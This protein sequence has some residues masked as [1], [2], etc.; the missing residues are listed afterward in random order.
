M[1]ENREKEWIIIYCHDN[2]DDKSNLYVGELISAFKILGFSVY[3]IN[4]KEDIRKE[5]TVISNKKIKLSLGI[6]GAGADIKCDDGSLL[7][8]KLAS[9]YYCI[10]SRHPAYYDN[11]LSRKINDYYVLC[12]DS[13]HID[14]IKRIYTHIKNAAIAQFI[15]YKE[16]GQ[17]HYHE[18]KYD[19]VYLDDNLNPDSILD[20]IDRIGNQDIINSVY[21]VIKKMFGN[22]HLSV[23]EAFDEVI[24][25]NYLSLNKE[26]Y[27]D[28]MC[29]MVL[30]EKYVYNYVKGIVIKKLI[31]NGISI[32]VFGKGWEQFDS[33]QKSNLKIHDSISY[34]EIEDVMKQSGI[35]LNILCNLKF[36][37]YD[38]VYM[39]AIAGAACVTDERKC[40]ND[41]FSH[42]EIGI[43]SL[44]RIQELSDLLIQLRNDDNRVKRLFENANSVMLKNY[45]WN[46]IADSVFGL[47]REDSIKSYIGEKGREYIADRYEDTQ[48]KL[49]YDLIQYG[50]KLLLSHNNHVYYNEFQ[51][52]SQRLIKLYQKEDRK[53][54]QDWIETLGDNK[55]LMMSVYSIMIRLTEDNVYMNKMLDIV[56]NSAF[57]YSIKLTVYWYISNYFFMR[58]NNATQ[59]TV[60]KLYQLYFEVVN[61]IGQ[62]C[63]LSYQYRL[64]ADR[65][66]DRVIVITSQFLDLRHGPTKTALD[67]CECLIKDFGMQVFLI[68]TGDLMYADPVICFYDMKEGSYVDDYVNRSSVVYNDCTI[69]FYQC[70][71]GMPDKKEIVEIARFIWEIN[72]YFILSIGGGN[73]TADICSEFCP[74]LS[75]ATVPSALTVTKGQFQVLGR[76]LN[77]YDKGI[78]RGLNIS[79]NHVIE[80]LFTSSLKQQMNHYSRKILGI[81]EEYFACILVGG[82]LDDELDNELVEKLLHDTEKNV[83]IV[84]AGKYE[85]YGSKSGSL[86]KFAE[87]FIYLGFQD[88]MLAV[89]E[90]CD[91]Y[92]NPL[93]TGG[94]TSAAEAMYKG[95]PVVTLPVGDVALGAG[96]YFHV[97]DYNEMIVKINRYSKDKRFYEEDSRRAK[98]RAQILFDTSKEFGS[99][100][101][102]MIQRM[103]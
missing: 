60:V 90:C 54:L 49:I 81:P 25:N 95:L 78:L 63:H 85:L 3:T 45:T 62:E 71:K 67:R 47:M 96:E 36:G 16:D 80:G 7:Q 97:K 20:E 24:E 76:Q 12:S 72:P 53:K 28:Y 43:F 70:K 2:V 39:S 40:I 56:L 46:K 10:I 88:D 48:E 34:S 86:E 69:P 98:K 38:E 89:L 33:S 8:N 9:P 21:N 4:V 37:G 5:I 18:K 35:V 66:I 11:I 26:E 65:N 29:Y 17:L 99:I 75:L 102:K 73:V 6:E 27:T 92:I 19:I 51:I 84:I 13:K 41:V 94:G 31:E 15:G 55:L 79:E 42:N 91:L 58:G 1:C 87:K 68:N 61:G 44:E 83:I 59:E 22:L 100:V 101:Q 14:Y 32:N 64:K 23:D 30:A 77:E 103:E 52:L 50:R 82:R 93:R 57:D 74:T